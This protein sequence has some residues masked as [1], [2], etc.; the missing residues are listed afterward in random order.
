MAL[1]RIKCIVRHLIRVPVIRTLFWKPTVPYWFLSAPLGQ[2]PIE[3]SGPVSYPGVD[4]LCYNTDTI[5]SSYYCNI[6]KP[7]GDLGSTPPNYWFVAIVKIFLNWYP[8]CN[9][10]Y[11]IAH[12]Y[13]NQLLT[14]EVFPQLH[15]DFQP[16]SLYN[17]N[18]EPVP[19]VRTVSRF[20][21]PDSMNTEDFISLSRISSTIRCLSWLF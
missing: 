12:C 7:E 1:Y 20:E 9:I 19:L 8:H 4:W 14:W 16:L 3:C 18:W 13:S 11:A 6:H 10:L 2:E 15:I 17:F 5:T 21:W